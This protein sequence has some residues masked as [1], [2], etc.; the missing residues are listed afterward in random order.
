[1]SIVPEEGSIIS[2][3]TNVNN[4]VNGKVEESS[5]PTGKLKLGNNTNLYWS[6]WNERSND[7]ECF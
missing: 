6:D 2:V 1:M 4:E 3:G 7:Y 5:S